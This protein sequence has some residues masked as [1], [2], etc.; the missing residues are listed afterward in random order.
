MSDPDVTS[1]VALAAHELLE[2]AVKYSTDG[3]TNIRVDVTPGDGVL[4]VCIRTRNK[5][6]TTNMAL[7]REY[8]D[9][10]KEMPDPLLFYTE[11]MAK[12]SKSSEGLGL[13]RIAAE[14]E[15][16]LAMV[17]VEGDMVEIRATADVPLEPS[18]ADGRVTVTLVGTADVRVTALEFMNSSCMKTFVTWIGLDQGLE[19]DKQYKI[20][21]RSNPEIHWQRRS[22]HALSR[23]AADLVT[24]E[25]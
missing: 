11:L 14:A 17:V 10:M 7:L 19:A 20:R 12:K 22:L 9:D 5:S 6:T 18:F 16:A 13:G 1:R 15:M 2:N 4:H 23:F 25:P 24:V 3:E 8:F 21:F